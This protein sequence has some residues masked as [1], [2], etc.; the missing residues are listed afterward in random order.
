L[1]ATFAFAGLPALRSA[2]A[3]PVARSF[4]LPA[5][6][7]DKSLSRFA[8][9]AGVDVIFGS[10]TAAQVRTNAVKGTYHPREALGLLLAHTG[11]VAFQDEKTGALTVSRDP[12]AQG[13][14]PNAASSDR[15]GNNEQRNI[16]SNEA[17][18]SAAMEGNA[19]ELSPFTVTSTV[20]TGYLAT[21]TLSGTR[22]NTNL[23]DIGAAVS[24]Y[25]PEFLADINVTKLED[26]LTYTA[27]TEG[28]GINGNYSG[29]TG[30]NSAGVRDDPSAV[31]RVRGLAQATRTR[32]FFPAD[33]PSDTY[34]F[35]SLTINRGPNAILAGVGNAGGVIDTALRKAAFKD[36]YRFVF[37]VDNLGSHREEIHLNQVLIPG[38]L[39]VRADL[40]DENQVFR[41]DPAYANDKRVY[42]AA[43]YRLREPKDQAFMGRTTIRANTE[44]GQ[45]VGVPPDPLTPIFSLSSWLDNANPAY[46]KW[47]YNGALQSYTD[48]KG[49]P[50]TANAVIVGFPLY[51]QWALIYADPNSGRAGVGFTAPDLSAVQGFM[52][53]VTGAPT[54][55]GG[56]VLGTGD[57]D[58]PRAG[59]ARTRLSNPVV[60]NFYDRLMTG[61][62]DH[63][64]QQFTA[65][66]LRL[67]QLLLG[68]KAGFEAAYNKQSL[69]RRRDIPIAG[70]D[71]NIYIDVNTNLSMRSAAYPNG[72][73]NPNFGRPFINSSD[74][75]RDQIN[76]SKRES[77]QLT[78]Y[79]KHDFTEG[80]SPLAKLLGRH[81][82][83]GLF[84]KT[85]VFLSNRTYHSTW[86]PAGQ[87]NVLSSLGASPGT[88]NTQVAAWFYLGDSLLNANSLNDVRLNPIT[89]SRPQY[90]QTY[91]LRVYDSVSNSFV[92]GTSTPL[93][94]LG[95][96]LDQKQ[97]LHSMAFALQSHWLRDHV[98]TLVGWRRDKDEA[99]TSAIPPTLA[100]GSLDESKIIYQPAAV[101]SKDSWTKSVVGTCPIRLPLGTELRAFWND[102]GNFNPVGQRRNLWNEEVGSPSASTRE[103]GVMLSLLD[104]KFSLRINHYKTSIQND[105]IA[106]VSNPYS[107]I[108]N[109]ITRMV[110]ANG[111][112]LNPA[113][114]GYNYSGFKT[115]AD[116][117]Q[118]FYATI[119]QRL[120]DNIGPDKNFNPHFSGQGSTL[121]WNADNITNR[122][123][124]SETVSTGNEFEAIVN[125]TLSWRISASVAKNE[126]IQADAAVQ[127]LD[128][129]DA[130]KRNLDTMY[131]GNLLKGW[132]NPPI[133]S[134]TIWGQYTSG[135]V[136]PLQTSHALSGTALPEIRKWRANLVT[137]YDFRDGFLRGF[138]IGGAVRWQ[139]KVGIGYPYLTDADGN[140]VADINHPYWGPHEMNI[141]ANLGYRRRIKAG[142]RMINWDIG[143]NVRNLNARDELIPIK[144]NGDGTWGIFRI[145]PNRAWS[146]TNSFR[147]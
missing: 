92:T 1:A 104:G 129:V 101:E 9:Q 98:T 47:R 147:F 20:E 24:V 27:S 39:A 67:E 123:S 84:F 58:R 44:A 112:G 17:V 48:A 22:L 74:V 29:I 75:F 46:N 120:K 143:L 41:Q 7:G 130:W 14:A 145:P 30:D 125:P 121:A 77:Y 86:D 81:T 12:K 79:L 61:V 93:R 131:N 83:S 54:G 142:G 105:A 57:P 63:R 124:V 71:E 16:P 100:N 97:D 73:P 55:P 122:V 40:M 108:S 78:A 35:D 59:F 95:N 133:A 23:K 66:D 103:Y 64:D 102:S 2:T 76:R 34:N 38:K 42:L 141:D 138:H 87:L 50:I 139:D 117:A 49:S 70:G 60:F 114:Y 82:L 32:D 8:V 5:D 140:Q 51:T 11:L 111:Q 115:F 136:A 62:F 43:T 107:Y 65:S 109:E 119:P 18:M 106:N 89:S 6:T 146:I 56:S 126:A 80:R 144:A 68:G 3:A 28:G 19:V 4:D 132:R 134:G 85:D 110:S 26:I 99:L 25:T 13:A 15:P 72:I 137:R 37:R 69:T 36:S 128:F 116:V 10:A 91:T 127:E 88:F 113:L 33:I 31:N 94:I 96:V 52:G 90:G 21:N 53:G 118:A 45:I 135:T